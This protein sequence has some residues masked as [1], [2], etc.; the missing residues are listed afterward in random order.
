MISNRHA[1]EH[2]Q[3]S[4]GPLIRAVLTIIA[5]AVV[6]YVATAAIESA[7]ELLDPA[8][9]SARGFEPSRLGLGGTERVASDAATQPIDY[10]PARITVKATD[11]DRPQAD[12][13]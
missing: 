9:A 2:P 11:D 5:L 1:E 6:A 3:L 13:F 10:L 12:T 4:F 8:S 7:G